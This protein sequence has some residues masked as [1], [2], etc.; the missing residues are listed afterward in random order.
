MSSI[1]TSSPVQETYPQE[2]NVHPEHLKGICTHRLRTLEETI[3][4]FPKSIRGVARLDPP[5]YTPVDYTEDRKTSR[6]AMAVQSMQYHMTDEGYQIMLGL[7]EGGGY[8]LA[9]YNCTHNIT[10]TVEI[11]KAL[12]PSTLVIQD[13]REWD[14][15]PKD[16][17]DK[18]AGFTRIDYLKD[19]DS[20]FKVTVLKDAQQRPEYH[21]QSAYEMGVH[22]WI[23]Y[24]NSVIVSRLAPYTRPEHFIRT[25]HS[26]DSKLVPLFL[27]GSNERQRRKGCLLSGAIGPAY[28]LRTLLVR[29]KGHLPDTDILPHPGYHMRGCNTPSYLRTLSNYKVAI[30]TSSIYGYALR[31]IIEATACGCRVVTDLPVD[32]VLPNIDGNLIRVPPSITAT[33]MGSLLH[34]LY[35][36]YNTEE[37]FKYADAC[38]RFYDYRQVG[39]RLANDIES[40][41]RCYNSEQV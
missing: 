34:R 32:E 11:V 10:D 18:R 3:F 38:M 20:V 5:A 16:F 14:L 9:G 17:R 41:K 15:R 23:V 27:P 6:V 24:Y 39:I 31:K 2:F 21:M 37:Q 12:N 29:R 4:S 28:P 35:A 7:Q 40:M 25:Y 22:A 26:I 19:Q 1:P 36:T 30:C 13:K 8:T 33:Q